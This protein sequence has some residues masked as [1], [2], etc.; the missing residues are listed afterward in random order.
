M[1]TC[2][3]LLAELEQERITQDNE[4]DEE[5]EI[6]YHTKACRAWRKLTYPVRILKDPRQYHA[7][8]F[9]TAMGAWVHSLGFGDNDRRYTVKETAI[10]YAQ[11]WC[12]MIKLIRAILGG[13]VLFILCALVIV[14][15]C[16]IGT[17]LAL[18]ALVQRDCESIIDLLD[19][20]RYAVGGLVASFGSI[21]YFSL[22]CI[23]GPV[24]AIGVAIASC[25][26][27]KL[28]EL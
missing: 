18:V 26:C 10:V 4:S 14:F 21:F 9:K 8:T 15:G 20:F 28:P 23:F 12:T 5:E 25:T 11:P 22:V 1:S 17:L 13:L 6:S 3:E 7:G 19:F 2:I 27:K 24:Y 16:I